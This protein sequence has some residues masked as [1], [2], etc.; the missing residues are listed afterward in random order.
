MDRYT[1]PWPPVHR[2]FATA[3]LAR[4]TLPGAMHYGSNRLDYGPNHRSRPMSAGRWISLEFSSV[5]I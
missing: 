4:Q 3:E 1:F 5:H 2:Q